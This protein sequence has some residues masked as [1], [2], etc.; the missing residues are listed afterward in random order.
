MGISILVVEDES[1][2]SILIQ[3]FCRELGYSIAD[4]VATGEDAIKAVKENG[5]DLVLMDIT[6]EGEMDGIDCA[7]EI[8][9]HY[10][11]PIIYITTFSDDSTL[12]RAKTTTPFGYIIKPVDK[13]DLKAMIEMAILRHNL[14]T[15][16]KENEN[17]VSTILNSIGDGVVVVNPEKKISYI[18][19]IT[20]MMLDTSA[21][22]VMDKKFNEIIHLENSDGK[23]LDDI[24]NF[25]P[26]P[27]YNARNY[28]CSHNGLKTPVDFR[29]T[30][31]KD[32][33][34]RFLGTVMIFRDITERVK[35]EDRINESLAQLRKA[36]GGIIGAMAQ[37]VESRDP[38][39]AGHQ[40]KVADLARSIAEMMDLPGE[41]IEGI[42]MAG[43]IHDLGKISI[44]AEILS[45]P[46]KITEVEFNLIKAHPQT[47]YDILKTIEFPWP[48]AE[49][50]YQHHERLDG[51]GYPRGLKGDEISIEARVMAVADVVEAMASH[52]PYRPAL[53]VEMALDEIKKNAGKLY[54]RDVVEACIRLF[55]ETDYSMND[56][57]K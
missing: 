53:G 4:A 56:P 15:R 25:T 43:V 27:E 30:P 26:N 52:R 42:R 55:R 50:V 1:I 28:I 49:I 8:Y 22:N 37:T 3:K 47:G 54:D 57:R 34:G 12:E 40:R 23:I 10:N 6:L 7:R 29:V 32:E 19:P 46:G 33:R 51:S 48:V 16:L 18:N 17:K 35:S 45:K 5:V 11:S 36:M 24:H 14:E 44:P 20:E 21:D 31:Q 41:K 9:F 38:Y 2:A 13:K 39:T